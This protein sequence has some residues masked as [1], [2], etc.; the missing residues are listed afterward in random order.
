MPSSFRPIHR[1]LLRLDD[2][3]RRQFGLR[4]ALIWQ[5]DQQCDD[6]TQLN[7]PLRYVWVEADHNSMLVYTRLIG[8][9]TGFLDDRP[10]LLN[11]AFQMRRQCG[12][13]HL[14]DRI[15]GRTEF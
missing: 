2:R 9:N 10:P 3:D 13:S 6:R 14:V 11:L 12:R 1:P 5:T 8:V 4:K 7:S 15:N